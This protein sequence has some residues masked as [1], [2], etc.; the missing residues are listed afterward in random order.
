MESDIVQYTRNPKRYKQKRQLFKNYC[1]LMSIRLKYKKARM[2]DQEKEQKQQEKEIE[3]SLVK[4][5]R[6]ESAADNRRKAIAHFYNVKQLLS[7]VL[8]FFL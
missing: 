4:R 5:I 3:K 1:R 2:S 7:V 8:Y 6:E